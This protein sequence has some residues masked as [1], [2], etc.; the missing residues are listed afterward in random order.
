MK[1]LLPNSK[2]KR[3]ANAAAAG[4]STITSSVYDTEGV[5][6]VTFLAFLGD[7]TSGSVLTFKLQHGA[8]ADGSDMADLPDALVSHT[9]D[10]S[11]ADNKVLALEAIRPLKR[12][13]RAQLVRGTANAVLDGIVAIGTCPA[14][15]PTEHDAS[16]LE[17][18]SVLHPEAA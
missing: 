2:I 12:Y 1:N 9:A 8:Q 15:A 3:V 4:T 10:A 17:S 14:V 13:M 5:D 18:K 6:A 16:V 11:D 7:V